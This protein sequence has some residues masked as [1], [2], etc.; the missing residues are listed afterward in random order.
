MNADDASVSDKFYVT[1]HG[2]KIEDDYKLGILKEALEV[3]LS[4]KSIFAGPSRPKFSLDKG[5]S[6]ATLMGQWPGAVVAD[7]IFRQLCISDCMMRSLCAL[8]SA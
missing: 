3:V 2:K 1:A 6:V 4:S 5:Q 7:N 8:A